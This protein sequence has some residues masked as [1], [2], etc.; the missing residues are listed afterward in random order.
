V[1]QT[2]A[3]AEVRSEAGVVVLAVVRGADTLMELD[4][5]TFRFAE[6]DAVVIAGTRESVRRFE[7]AFLG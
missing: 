7:A 5:N 4:P 6:G 3:E 1:G 2:L